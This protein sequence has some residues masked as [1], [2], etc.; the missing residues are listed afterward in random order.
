HRS[1]S[2][3]AREARVLLGMALGPPS[4]TDRSQADTPRVRLARQSPSRRGGV[5]PRGGGDRS[6][7][8][9]PSDGAQG[10]ASAA[11]KPQ[12]RVE[13]GAGRSAR[14]LVSDQQR[15]SREPEVVPGEA[16]G[17]RPAAEA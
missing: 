15:A 6:F 2:D 17:P 16:V 9:W 13:R 1:P 3:L 7:L 5:A 12:A 8:D 11:P 14:L 10:P 4:R